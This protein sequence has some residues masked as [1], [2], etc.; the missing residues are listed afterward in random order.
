MLLQS[1]WEPPV[2]E[3]ERSSISDVL[4]IPAAPVNLRTNVVV[5]YSTG[6]VAPVHNMK[7]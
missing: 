4:P 2:F 5:W 1:S 3:T 6:K 7:Q